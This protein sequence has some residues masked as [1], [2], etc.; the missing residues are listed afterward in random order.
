M[1]PIPGGDHRQGELVDVV[2]VDAEFGGEDLVAQ[3]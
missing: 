1:N 3:A 2:G